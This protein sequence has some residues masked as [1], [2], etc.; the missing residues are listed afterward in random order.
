MEYGILNVKMYS[1]ICCGT[2]RTPRTFSV[3]AAYN[4]RAKVYATVT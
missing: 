4:S 2:R 1:G 3:I